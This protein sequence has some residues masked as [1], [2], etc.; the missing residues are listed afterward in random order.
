[1]L[2]RRTRSTNVA[3]Y[4]LVLSR[5]SGSIFAVERIKSHV[6]DECRLLGFCDSVEVRRKIS[7]NDEVFCTSV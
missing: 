3:K 7:A 4:E 1:M 2:Y 5:C 6:S